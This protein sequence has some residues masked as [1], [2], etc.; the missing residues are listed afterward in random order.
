[1]AFSLGNDVVSL[2]FGPSLSSA[3]PVMDPEIMKLLI[4]LQSLSFCLTGFVWFGQA[5]SR[6]LLK[7]NIEG[8]VRRLSLRVAAG[9]RLT[10]E[11]PTSLSLSSVVVVVP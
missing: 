7:W 4:M 6:S 8:L 3:P 11:P 1:M 2:P 9:V 10:P 5:S